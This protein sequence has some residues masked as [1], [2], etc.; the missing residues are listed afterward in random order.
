MKLWVQTSGMSNT[1]PTRASR[2][3]LERRLVGVLR[4]HGMRSSVTKRL[5]VRRNCGGIIVAA[6]GLVSLLVDVDVRLQTN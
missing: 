6:P 2:T 3:A 1:Q 4:S 5:A